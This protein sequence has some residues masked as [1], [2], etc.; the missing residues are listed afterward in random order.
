MAS[1]QST[2]PEPPKSPPAERGVPSSLN[3]VDTSWTETV[4]ETRKEVPPEITA[5]HFPPRLYV[6]DILEM[7]S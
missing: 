3:D 1:G 7:I 5:G 2:V 6:P 4:E